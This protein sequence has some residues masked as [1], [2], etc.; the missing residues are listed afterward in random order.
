MKVNYFSLTKFKQKI[1]HRF[2][3][4][5]LFFFQKVHIAKF[6][7]QKFIRTIPSCGQFLFPYYYYNYGKFNF[8]KQTAL[9]LIHKIKIIYFCYITTKKLI[10]PDP[11]KNPITNIIPLA[12]VVIFT[13][14]K[15]GYED[16]LRHRADSAVNN[17]KVKVI[18]NGNL[19]I[20]KRKEIK[21]CRV[22]ITN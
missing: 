17:A 21:V 6:F 16:V 2:I 9:I 1:F 4:N 8:I 3:L 18:R 12:I 7:A 19:V 11:P 10:I 22:L 15:Q 20:I 14:I 5:K 13:A